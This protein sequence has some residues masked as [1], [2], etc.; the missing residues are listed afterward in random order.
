M[1]PRYA[2]LGLVFVV[3]VAACGRGEPAADFDIGPTSTEPLVSDNHLIVDPEKGFPPEATT[4]KFVARHPHCMDDG[5]PA[6]TTDVDQRADIITIKEHLPAEVSPKIA[7]NQCSTNYF[8]PVEVT[9][10]SPLGNRRL[11]DGSCTPPTEI[12]GKF[13][14]REPC[15]QSPLQKAARD[16]IGT[17]TEL[18]RGPI[19]PRGE[20]W[21]AWTGSEMLIVGGLGRTSYQS[22]SSGAAFNPSTNT[23]RPLADPPAIGRVRAVTW[24]GSEL[25]VLSQ[26]PG[27][28]LIH[29]ADSAHLF[30][31]ATNTWR[32][33]AGPPR[34]NTM[35]LTFWTGSEV[36]MWGDGGGALYNPSTNTWREIPPS[37]VVGGNVGTRAR[38]IP[39]PGVLSVQSGVDPRNG[40]PQVETLL[41][42]NPSTNTWRQAAKP[43]SPVSFSSEAVV[44]G[45]IEI[46]G[47]GGSGEPAT[48]TLAYDALG[49]KWHKYD[50]PPEGCDLGCAYFRGF[51]IGDGR[52]IVRIGSSVTPLAIIDTKTGKWSHAVSPGRLPAADTAFVWTGSEALLWGQPTITNGDEPVAAWRWQPYAN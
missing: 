46:F 4:L 47:D 14:Q 1:R 21:S 41:L 48:E 7:A 12:P 36:V 30:N 38:W 44:V 6:V 34:P 50:A 35:P 24:T 52:A 9:L 28:T 51:D 3:T 20:P 25:F 27:D 49:D 13:E 39:K 19:A 2:A 10:T 29:N 5:P 33:A 22:M 17:W 11:F 43:P 45:S 8:A 32:A 18:D 31:P 15:T 42:F 40:S 37:D 16:A 23:W 26:A